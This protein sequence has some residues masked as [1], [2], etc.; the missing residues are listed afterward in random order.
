MQTPI[1]GVELLI[2]FMKKALA[3]TIINPNDIISIQSVKGNL[4]LGK[5][6]PNL[7]MRTKK[8]GKMSTNERNRCDEWR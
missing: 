2:L 5:G 1:V 4:F 8:F 6:M 7:T 3:Q